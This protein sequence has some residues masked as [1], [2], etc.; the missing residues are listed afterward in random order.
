MPAA[1]VLSGLVLIGWGG[2]DA[3]RLEKAK[4][5][6]FERLSLGLGAD[7]TGARVSVGLRF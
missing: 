2:H 3:R 7:A 1:G 6:Y 5:E 4:W